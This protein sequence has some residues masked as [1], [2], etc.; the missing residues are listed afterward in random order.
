LT[1]H[2]DPR[3]RS[4]LQRVRR[5]LSHVGSDIAQGFFDVSHNGF[6]VLGVVVAFVVITLTAR[7]DLR[8]AAENQLMALLVE[9]QEGNPAFGEPAAVNR[10]TAL[11]P[12]DLPKPQAALAHWLSRKYGVAPEP[13]AALVAAAHEV[14]KRVEIDPTLI[15]AIMAV[16]SGFN[17]F[18]QSPMGAQGLM[19]VMTS[20]HHQKYTPFGGKLAAFDPVTNLRVGV[21]VLQA[22]IERAGSLEGGLKFYVGAANLQDDNGYANKVLAERARLQQVI[23]G[24]TVPAS[25]PSAFKAGAAASERGR[26]RRTRNCRFGCAHFLSQQSRLQAPSGLHSRACATGD[27]LGPLR[28][29]ADVGYTT[30]ERTAGP[31]R[32]GL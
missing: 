9:R 4:A 25:G 19:Q 22:C 27:R 18:A 30:G 6:A 2:L 24:K 14:G 7:P 31:L 15:L 13:V 23:E 21:R 29:T 26:Q 32:A 12:S 16:E 1:E 5:S 8:E 3:G 28:A 20:V 10:A 11:N 17:P